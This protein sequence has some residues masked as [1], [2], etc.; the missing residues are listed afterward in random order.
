[1]T[2]YIISDN[3]LLE[4]VSDRVS[5]A[6]KREIR[7]TIFNKYPIS[8]ALKAE[9]ER[10]KKIVEDIERVACTCMCSDTLDCPGQSQGECICDGCERYEFVEEEYLRNYIHEKAESLRSE[11]P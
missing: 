2:D 8:S 6:R 3:W 11:Q 5:D 7:D 4:L 9:R 1:M 10:A